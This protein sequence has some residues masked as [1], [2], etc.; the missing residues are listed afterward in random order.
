MKNLF[1]DLA[2]MIAVVSAVFSCGSFDLYGFTCGMGWFFIAIGA[3][4]TALYFNEEEME[5]EF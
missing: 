4:L 1:S 5:E 2:L 3:I